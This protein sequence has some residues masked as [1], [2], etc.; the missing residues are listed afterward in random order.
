MRTGVR[1]LSRVRCYI[2]STCRVQCNLDYRKQEQEYDTCHE[3]SVIRIIGSE[4]PKLGKIPV[5]WWKGRLSEIQHYVVQ[6]FNCAQF[7]QNCAPSTV[8]KCHSNEISRLIWSVEIGIECNLMLW[9]STGGLTRCCPRPPVIGLW[10]FGART[11]PDQEDSSALT[12]WTCPL[13]NF[14]WLLKSRTGCIWRLISDSFE[15]Y[16]SF[17]VD[18][19]TLHWPVHVTA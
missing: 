1:Y 14:L 17:M 16:S 4:C 18:L 6:R 15:Y 3:Y 9:W 10:R 8:Q 11:L 13:D 19:H 7:K 5:A 2:Q 12:V